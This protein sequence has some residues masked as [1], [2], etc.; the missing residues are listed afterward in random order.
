MKLIILILACI[1]LCGCGPKVGR[2]ISREFIPEHE[3]EQLVLHTDFGGDQHW[4][5][6]EETIPNSWNV[7]ITLDGTN[8]Y[9]HSCSEQSYNNATNGAWYD[10]DAGIIPEPQFREK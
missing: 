8:F 9:D 10:V 2:V 4:D 7:T 1:I 6:D 3:E 5:W